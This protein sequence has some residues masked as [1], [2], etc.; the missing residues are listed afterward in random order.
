MQFMMMCCI[1]E[2]RWDALPAASRDAIM[3]D[4]GA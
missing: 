1:E 4:Y 2:K 3:R